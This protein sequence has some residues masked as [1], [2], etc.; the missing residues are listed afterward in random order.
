MTGALSAPGRERIAGLVRRFREDFGVRSVPVDSFVLMKSVRE[1]GNL[2]L[3]RQN[4]PQVP[5]GEAFIIHTPGTR[6]YTIVTGG[7]PPLDWKKYSSWRRINFTLAHELGHLFCGHLEVPHS[8]KSE[9]VRA[10][11]DAEA[12]AFAAELLVPAEALAFFCT[13]KEAADA[14]W[15]SESAV[16]RRMRD[17]GVL[18][19]MRTCPRCGFSRIPPAAGFC[20]MCGA[21]VQPVPRPPEEPE[22]P[23]L[24]PLPR[25][26][27]VCGE[28]E[29]G[30]VGG[31]CLNCGNPKRNRCM[32][33]YDQPPHFCPDDARFCEICGAPTV[34]RELF[35]PP[36]S[37]SF[38]SSTV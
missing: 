36:Y 9:K 27:P 23:F 29:L 28:T 38:C 25:E 3:D 35:L 8:L 17:T 10:L 12:D 30:S 34:Y 19:A 24:P 11:E 18:P 15:V 1:K 7:I 32:P 13:V 31:E 14:L 33:E 21:C 22:V 6:T 4:D 20:R 16:R 26:C 5:S 2:I 37:S